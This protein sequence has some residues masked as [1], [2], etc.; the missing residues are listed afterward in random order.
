MQ[1]F[2]HK[3]RLSIVAAVL[4]ALLIVP[5]GTA[6][7]ADGDDGLYINGQYVADGETIE[8]QDP[9]RTGLP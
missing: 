6:L 8:I 7:A 2:K 5:I 4:A 9:K 1:F 3:K